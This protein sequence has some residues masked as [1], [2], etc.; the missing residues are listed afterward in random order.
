MIFILVIDGHKGLCG[1]GSQPF[2]TDRSIGVSNFNVHH[3]EG[4]RNACP[5]HIPAGT[6]HYLLKVCIVFFLLSEPD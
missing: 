2:I 4:L 3:L 6:K 5:D 1:L